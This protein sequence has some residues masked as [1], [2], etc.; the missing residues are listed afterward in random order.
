[1]TEAAAPAAGSAARPPLDDVM[2]AMDVVDTL[3]RRQR[4]VEQELGEAGREQDLKERLRKIYAAQGIEVSDAVLEEGVRALKE[5]RFVYKPVP[6][7]FGTWLAGVYVRR[8]VWGKW[9]LGAVAVLAVVVAVWQV[10]VVGPRSALPQELTA[11]HAEVIKLARDDDADR[12]ADRMLASGEKAL[13]DGRPEGARE[14][15]ADLRQLREQLEAT[16]RLRIVNRPGQ[17][18]GVFRIPDINQA[19]KNYYVIVEAVDDRGLPV[20]VPVTNE[21]SGKTVVAS[22]FGLR[23]DKRIY[24]R[25]AADK[26]DDGI[27]QNDIVGHKDRGVLDPTYDIPTSGAAITTW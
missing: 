7:G 14:V 13:R 1:M 6:R 22:T 9:V 15:L 3:R 2:L 17:R 24:D 19:A 26:Q 27:I 23:V 20:K 4:L 21:E 16:Y 12:L 10:A 11:L 18:S 8:G 25:V 5:D